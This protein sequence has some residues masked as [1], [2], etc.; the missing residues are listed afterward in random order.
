MK[1]KMLST[2]MVFIMVISLFMVAGCQQSNELAEYKAAAKTGIE[3][4]AEDKGRSNY[5]EGNWSA[6]TGH[7]EDGKAAIDA[8]TDKAQV[9]IAVGAAKQKIDGVQ[10]IVT[11]TNN[12][13]VYATVKPEYITAV[14]QNVP[15]AFPSIN[16]K[17]V[18]ITAKSGN[19]FLELLFVLKEGASQMATVSRLSS[20]SRIEEAHACYN[21]PFE[22]KSTL[23]LTPS[24]VSIKV[25]ETL[26]IKREGD[27]KFYW[28]N[29]D[30]NSISISLKNTDPNK[31]YTP[32]DF[33]QIELAS[34]EKYENKINIY[35]VTFDTHFLLTLKM[36][37]YSNVLN[38]VNALALEPDFLYSITNWRCAYSWYPGWRISDTSIAEFIHAN[39]SLSSDSN[40]YISPNSVELTSGTVKIKGIK[41]GIVTLTY[42]PWAPLNDYAITHKIEVVE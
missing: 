28:E 25:G 16:F 15:D 34:V 37:G 38:A 18:L 42:A 10:Y 26:T 17:N 3:T 12:N 13:A 29:F 27:F 31:E 9:D 1:K 21:V 36:P 5:S 22:T 20:D 8:A 4:Y 24:A 39:G 35:G 40:S 11:W 14:L 2:V 19:T 33:P 32:A 6:I 7:V 30:F 41:P 23:S